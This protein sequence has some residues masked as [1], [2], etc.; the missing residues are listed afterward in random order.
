[1]KASATHAAIDDVTDLS[2]AASNVAPVPALASADASGGAP[3]LARAGDLSGAEAGAFDNVV[4]LDDAPME[5]KL[6]VSL[7]GFNGPLDLLLALA[8]T[9]KLDLVK[10]SILELTEQYLQFIH[11]AKALRLEIA[12]DYLVMA[13]WLAF[14]KS[15]LLL[16]AQEQPEEGPSGEEMA[17]HLAFRLKRLEAMRNAVARLFGRKQFGQDFFARGMPE[18]VRTIRKSEYWASVYDLLKAYADQR[19]RTAVAPVKMGGRTVWSVKEARERLEQLLGITCN[20][21]I[22]DSYLE[23]Y[24]ADEEQSKTAIASSFGA[25]LELAREGHAEVRQACAF[26]PL[27]VRW[28]KEKPSEVEASDPPATG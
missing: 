9:Q 6:Q 25:I 27:Y 22:L 5:D 26:A 17:L 19:R 20:W 28:L 21:S 18:G 16:P 24:L 8:R 13:A 23:E 7:E 12:A 11:D 10:I 15:K 1:M 14:L 2:A 3:D 4:M